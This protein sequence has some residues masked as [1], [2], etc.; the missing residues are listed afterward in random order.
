MIRFAY[1]IIAG[2]ISMAMGLVMMVAYWAFTA[3]MGARVL[4]VS[5]INAPS[6]YVNEVEERCHQIPVKA[7][8]S[9]CYKA[10]SVA[11]KMIP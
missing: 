8:E 10:T 6:G 9:L 7:A 1:R 5:K 3:H 11:K 2:L 4:N